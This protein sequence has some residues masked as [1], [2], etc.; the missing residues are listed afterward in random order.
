VEVGLRAL[1]R[2]CQTGCPRPGDLE[3]ESDGLGHIYRS[4]RQGVPAFGSHLGYGV[5]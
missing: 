4:D 2:V 3:L 1:T 5:N